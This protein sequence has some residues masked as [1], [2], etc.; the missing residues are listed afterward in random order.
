MRQQFPYPLAILANTYNPPPSYS[1]QN[2]QYHSQPPEVYQPYQY[3]QATTLVTQQLIQSPP[4]QSNSQQSYDIL[5]F[6]LYLKISF[7]KHQLGTSSNPRTQA[8]IQ[9]GQVTVQNFQGRQSQCYAGNAGKSKATGARIINTVGEAGE[10]QPM[11][12][13]CYNF[14]GKGHIAKQ[15]T[16]KKR[17]KDSEWFKD[18]MLLAQAQE[19]KVVLHEERQDFLADTLEENDDC[20]DLQ[21]HTTT[22]FKVDHI[23]AYDSDCDDEA[24]ASAIFMASLSLAGSLNDDTVAPTYDSDILSEV[25]HYD[26]YHDDDVLKSAVQETEYT[27]HYVSHDD[28]YAKLTSNINVISYAEYMVTIEDEDAH[29]F[30]PPA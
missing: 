3:Y 18:K 22:N 8:T 12:I 11:I 19:A 4:Q 16:A 1:S 30:L 29:Y 13:R 25:S 27:E 15:C 24:A 2:I 17:V 7:H 5:E 6:G 10:N 26:T 23:D 20:D 28:S 9:N 14:R 21:L